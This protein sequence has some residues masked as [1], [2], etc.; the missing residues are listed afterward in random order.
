MKPEAKFVSE[1][2]KAAT[3]RGWIVAP[4]PDPKGT[5]INQAYRPFDFVLI[6]ERKVFCVEAKYQNN[7]LLP[8]QKGTSEAI[9]T[10]N[11]MAYWII[12]KRRL[13]KGTV[14]SVEKYR[15]GKKEVIGEGGL[16]AILDHFKMVE[17]WENMEEK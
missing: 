13:L 10:I 14:Y 16:D 9:E 2:K 3:L 4:I 6:T 11:P 7:S 1:F 5:Y 17:N 15:N 8:H 12:R